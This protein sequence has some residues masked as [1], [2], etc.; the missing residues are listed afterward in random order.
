MTQ[1]FSQ[2]LLGDALRISCWTCGSLWGFCR[3]DHVTEPQRHVAQGSKN[4]LWER[5]LFFL[6]F[7]GLALNPQ[8]RNMIWRICRNLRSFVGFPGGAS[9]KEPACQCRR[10]KRCEFDPWVGRIPRRRAQQPTPVF[11]PREP[12][13]QRTLAGYHPCGRKESDTPEAT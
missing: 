8:K 13:G 11:L 7:H 5:P 1:Q 6:A 10:L 2:V 12:C 4:K 9:A 3:M